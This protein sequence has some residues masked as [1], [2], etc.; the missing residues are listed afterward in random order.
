MKFDEK[1]KFPVKLFLQLL[2]IHCHGISSS[3]YVPVDCLSLAAWLFLS[4]WPSK[5][6]KIRKLIT[7]FHYGIF[8][9]HFGVHEKI[10]KEN[11][12]TLK[13]FIRSKETEVLDF[14]VL[15]LT[16]CKAEDWPDC[17]P[18]FNLETSAMDWNPS[19]HGQISCFAV[20]YELH[21]L[22]AKSL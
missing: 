19:N 12:D 11:I 1:F 16:Y 5:S 8:Y 14:S 10:G 6:R 18:I 4:A 15:T 13:R 17:A 9:N 2:S 22:H 3:C 20:Q 7:M 21:L